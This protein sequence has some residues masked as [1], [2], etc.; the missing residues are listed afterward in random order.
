MTSHSDARGDRIREDVRRQDRCETSGSSRQLCLSEFSGRGRLSRAESAIAGR[1]WIPAELCLSARG[2]GEY[3]R[4]L[5]ANRDRT[6][7][8]NLQVIAAEVLL[9]A[10]LL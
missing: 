2:R 5:A 4:A 7:M 8:S 10:G 1:R 3:I 6:G 9:V